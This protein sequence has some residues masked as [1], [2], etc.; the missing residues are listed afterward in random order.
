MKSSPYILFLLSFLCFNSQ[1]Q[2]WELVWQDEFAG[3]SL[4]EQKWVH[5]IGT[6]SQNGL[7][8]WGNGEL[9]Y[10]KPVKMHVPAMVHVHFNYLS[11]NET[12]SKYRYITSYAIFLLFIIISIM[13]SCFSNNNNRDNSTIELKVENL[14]EQMTLEEKAGQMTQIGIPVILE[15]EG[16]WDAADTL[17]IDTIKLKKP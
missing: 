8:G 17:I 1:A 4:N 6:G 2:N 14:I 5:E 10:Y 7:W 16:Y 11:N 9:Q 12:M 15:Q 13:S 3:S